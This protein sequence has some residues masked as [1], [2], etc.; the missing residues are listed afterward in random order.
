ESGVVRED[1]KFFQP[2]TP[3][4][5][6]YFG[7]VTVFY[8]E[9]TLEQ[10]IISTGG[11]D[12][13]TIQVTYQGC[14]DAGL[15]Y[16]PKTQTALYLNPAVAA[17]NQA[18]N[19]DAQTSEPIQTQA[20]AQSTAQESRLEVA[21]SAPKPSAPA[22][23]S[24]MLNTE[25]AQSLA[26][27]IQAAALWQTLGVFFLLGIGLAFTPCVFPMIPILSTI[28]AGQKHATTL[29]SFTLSLAYVLGM[30]ALYAALGFI[31]GQ[32]GAGINLQAYLQEPWV[33]SVFAGLFFVLAL[34]MFGLY[35]LQLPE[36]LRSR[37]GDLQHKQRG[38]TLFQVFLMGAV[39]ALVVSPCVSAPLAGAMIYIASTG[40]AAL[41]ALVL[42]AMAL[43]MGIPLVLF[44]TG[45][46]HWLPRAGAWMVAVRALF[47][48]MLI[49]VAIWLLERFL[50]GPVT[51]LLWALLAGVSAVYLGAF[52]PV[53]DGWQRLWKGVGLLL[54]VYAIFLL[55]GAATGASDPLR[56]FAALPSLQA[57][58]SVTSPSLEFRTVYNL[59]QL[60]E[61]VAAARS[62]GQPLMLDFYADWCVSCKIMERDTFPHPEVRAR[63]KDVRLI[64]A[65]VTANDAGN[66]ALLSHFGLYGPPGI[67]FFDANGAELSDRRIYGEMKT[68][69]FVAHLDAL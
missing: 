26:G 40:D 30:A 52:E 33:L 22:S 58:A 49:A 37:L 68:Q 57:Q 12:E 20:Q 25:S 53:H 46:G 19:P 62:A 50:A 24:S 38:G 14:A 2:G 9:L 65:D 18:D 47:G 29:S 42:F 4:D 69:E 67:L 59:D 43:G 11:N 44:G 10:P 8:N 66:Q 56:P 5:D 17:A 60:D 34:S 13:L 3:K 6:A 15:C 55:A 7:P 31:V 64:K 54:F 23:P 48:V 51:L 45:A 16:P 28:V 21:D 1:L 41:G 61:E 63:L 27:F 35:E 32:A 39:S 36:F